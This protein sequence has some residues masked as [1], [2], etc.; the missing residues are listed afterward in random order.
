MDL[1][2]EDFV[3]RVFIYVKA[4]DGGNGAVSFRREK[5]VPKGGPDG[6]DGGDGGFVILRAS[7]NLSTLLKFKHQ[8]KFVAENGQHGRGKKQSGKSGE[9]LIIDVPVGT[10]VKDARSGEII[11]D[12]NRHGMMVCVAR[13]GKGGRGNA[14]FATST[15]RAPRIAESGEKGEE[16]WLELELKLLAD[17]ALIGF[18]NVGKSSLIAAMSNARPK[19]ADYPFTTLVPNL[20]VVKLDRDV[21]YVVADIP[22][23]IEGAHRGSG[24]GNLFLRH[25]ERCSVLVHVID[26]ASVE[27]RDFLKDY[28]TIL[29]EL[30]KYNPELLKKPQLLVANKIDLLDEDELNGRLEKLKRHANREIIPVSALTRQ[31]IDTLKEKIA[32]F[33]GESKLKLSMLPAPPFEKPKPIKTRLELKFDFEIVR[34]KEGFV[35]EGE[36]VKAWLNRYSLEHRDALVRFLEVLEKNGLSEKLKQAGAKDGDT[37]WI[38]DYDFEY[39]E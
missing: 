11:A 27:G 25:I 35:V 33:V 38:G 5:Y 20:G 9:D 28:D 3:D 1:Q 14:H 23:L 8:K 6:G 19:I 32:Q 16:R 36:Q 21:E 31:N 13:G 39:R 17:A 26:I 15:L 7:A 37:V 34:T 24:L 2:K 18:P 12:L 4:G 29:E 10:V 22:G 30:S